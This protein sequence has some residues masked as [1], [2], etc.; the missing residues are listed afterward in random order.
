MTKYFVSA[1]KNQ[2]LH[3]LDPEQTSRDEVCRLEEYQ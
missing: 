2:F 3:S 1:S